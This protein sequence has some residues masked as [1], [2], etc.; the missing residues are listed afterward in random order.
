MIPAS[1]L[2]PGTAVRVEGTLYK[3]L[4]ADY[5]AGSGKMGG[6]THARLRNLETGT[7]T[8]RRFRAD[9]MLATIEPERRAMQYLYGDGGKSVFM[10]P[11]TFEQVEIE[12]ERLGQALAFLQEGMTLPV[13]F[14][15]DRPVAVTFP[16]IVEVRVAETA[17]PLHGQGASNVWKEARLENGLTVMVPPFIAPGESIRLQVE[18]VT[19]LERAK[20]EKK[21]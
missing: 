6:V 2:R 18:S 11:E 3:V 14:V 1:E 19:Y 21:G 9:E 13:E 7:Q 5:H 16:D 10:H 8:E 4:A 12:N 17:P 20:G 15:E